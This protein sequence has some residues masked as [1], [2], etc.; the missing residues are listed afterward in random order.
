VVVACV[1]LSGE[2]RKVSGR[3]YLSSSTNDTPYLR[4]V[5]CATLLALTLLPSLLQ[6]HFLLLAAACP[7]G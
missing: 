1:P 2:D 5:Y 6:T 3:I 4:M 7:A